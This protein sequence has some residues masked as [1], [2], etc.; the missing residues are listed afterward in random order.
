[1]E[2][3]KDDTLKKGKNRSTKDDQYD[4]EVPDW[5]KEHW[6]KFWFDGSYKSWIK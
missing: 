4:Y 6:D 1:M 2:T 5:A 3:N